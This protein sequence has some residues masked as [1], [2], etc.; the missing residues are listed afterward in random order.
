MEKKLIKIE[1][2]KVLAVVIA[3]AVIA[4]VAS[5]VI[6]T[7]LFKGDIIMTEGTIEKDGTEITSGTVETS[8]DTQA[9]SG[10]AEIAETSEYTQ[11]TSATTATTVVK[12]SSDVDKIK[13]DANVAFYEKVTVTKDMLKKVISDVDEGAAYIKREADLLAKTY[14]I[15][16]IFVT[17]LKK[18][19]D[20]AV[21]VFKKNVDSGVDLN[22]ALSGL[23][24]DVSSDLDVFKKDVSAT[25]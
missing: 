15:K 21:A 25:L 3:I 23:R 4:G 19:V 24:S 13:S 1:I 12:F 17:T 6:Q 14:A 10:T 8:E 2:G 11:A 20:N 9:T 18:E 22:K 16:D 7:Q 5:L